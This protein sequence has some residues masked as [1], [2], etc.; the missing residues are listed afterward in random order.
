LD[1]TGG[2]LVETDVLG[3]QYPGIYATPGTYGITGTAAELE[4]SG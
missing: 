4:Y 2:F 3:S 1:L